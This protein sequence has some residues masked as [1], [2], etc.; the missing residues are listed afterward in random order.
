MFSYVWRTQWSVGLRVVGKA[1]WFKID[2]FVS[3]FLC[4]AIREN[5]VAEG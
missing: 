4:I 2:H 5:A 3:M 1:S